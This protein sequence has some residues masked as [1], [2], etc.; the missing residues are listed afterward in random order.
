MPAINEVYKLVAQYA[1]KNSIDFKSLKI[2]L[3]NEGSLLFS[4]TDKFRTAE[5]L[6]DPL[7]LL[8]IVSTFI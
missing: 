4:N 3:C 1:H 8:V 6:S 7:G 2:A 5:T